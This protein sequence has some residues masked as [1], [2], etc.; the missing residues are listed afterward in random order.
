MTAES[1]A[2]DRP[3]L[4]ALPKLTKNLNRIMGT[5]VVGL[6]L[7]VLIGNAIKDWQQFIAVMLTGTVVFELVSDWLW[8]RRR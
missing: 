3:K 4:A 2:A 5:V 7:V 6:V 8:F 1:P